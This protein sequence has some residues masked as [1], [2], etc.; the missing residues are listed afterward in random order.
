MAFCSIPFD[1]ISDFKHKRTSTHFTSCQLNVRTFFHAESITFIPFYCKSLS[2]TTDCNL[3]EKH[4]FLIDERCRTIISVCWKLKLKHYFVYR[5][6]D[7]NH[8]FS[9]VCCHFFWLSLIYRFWIAPFEIH[10][11]LCILHKIKR[12]LWWCGPIGDDSRAGWF[13]YGTIQ[14]VKFG[15]GHF[16]FETILKIIGRWDARNMYTILKIPST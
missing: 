8:I 2:N 12:N 1:H 11:S 4:N 5:S 16:E 6:I 7:R 9:Y 14:S 3:F 15:M 10:R 13:D